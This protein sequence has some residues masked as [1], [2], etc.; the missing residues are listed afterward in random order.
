M[1]PVSLYN[2][3]PPPQLHHMDMPPKRTVYMPSLPP[4]LL[5][6]HTLCELVLEIHLLTFK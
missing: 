3:P 2:Y 6:F 1:S 5:Q 4:F